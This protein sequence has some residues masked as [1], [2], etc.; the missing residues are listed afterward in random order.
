MSN[1]YKIEGLTKKYKIADKENVILSN[2]DLVIPND[3]ITVIIGKSG[4]GKTTLLRMIAGLEDRTSGEIKFIDGNEEV[5]SPKIGFVFQESRL[6][7][8]LTIKENT[9]IHNEGKAE[10]TLTMLGLKEYINMYPDQLSGGMAQRVSIARAL[11]YN[12]DTLLMDEPFSALDYFTRKQLLDEILNIYLKTKK[13]IIFVTHNI[14]EGLTLGKNIFVMKDKKIKAY[15]INESY[16]RN[17][18]NEDMIK[19]KNQILKDII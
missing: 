16:P 5:A 13:G 6:L 14:E 4:C 7:P 15:R 12:P 17:L 8:W 1:L 10:E 2:L 3:E 19:L 11:C 9:Q 18:D